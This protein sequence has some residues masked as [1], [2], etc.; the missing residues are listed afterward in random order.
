M[1]CRV[2]HGGQ[3]TNSFQVKTGVRQ[4]CLL[5]LFLFLVAIDWIMKTSTSERRNGIQ[6]TLWSQPDNLDFTS[7]LALL[8]HS[9]QQIQEKISVLAATSAQ[10]GLI[11]HKEKT[12]ILKT[13]FSNINPITLYGSPLEE[14][15]FFTY[16]GSIIDQQGGTDADVKAR[17][18]SPSS[19]SRTS[20]LP[21]S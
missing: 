1:T 21:E 2:I 10:V 7:N 20:G 19:S 13:N 4:G 8:S 17:Q 3:L 14:V 9:Q 18:E 12:K 11:I 15:Q 5:S 16:L 6:W